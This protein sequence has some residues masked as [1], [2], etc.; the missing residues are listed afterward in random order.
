V[1]VAVPIT[2]PEVV[3]KVIVTPAARGRTVPEIVNGTPLF[4]D[5]GGFKM[6]FRATLSESAGDADA[7]R[8]HEASVRTRNDTDLPISIG[9]E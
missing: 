6:R 8:S 4:T 7:P 3:A 5:V 9:I 1:V 2:L